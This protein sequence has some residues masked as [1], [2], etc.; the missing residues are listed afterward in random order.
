LSETIEREATILSPADVAAMDSRRQLRCY[1]TFILTLLVAYVLGA[2]EYWHWA[3]WY[4]GHIA[5]LYGYQDRLLH[6]HAPWLA[7]QSRVLAPLLIAAIRWVTGSDY[8]GAYQAF[9]FWTFVGINC[10]A[11]LLYRLLGL[12]IGRSIVGLLLAAAVPMLLLNYWWF[13]WTNLECML[14][15]LLFSIDATAWKTGVRTAA[16]GIVF[17]ALVLTKETAVFVPIWIFLRRMTTLPW[18]F[19]W[20]RV[21]PVAALSFAMAIASLVVDSELRRTLW[22][23]G[24]IPGWPLG[25]P[26]SAAVLGGSMPNLLVWPRITANYYIQ[27]ALALVTGRMPWP[28]VNNPHWADHSAGAIDFF[29]ILGVSVGGAVRSH[30]QRESTLLAL[31]LLSISYLL[32]CVV[33]INMAESDKLLP[34]LAMGAYAYAIANRDG[35]ISR[36]LTGPIPS[37]GPDPAMTDV[38]IA[39]SPN[40]VAL[41]RRPRGRRQQ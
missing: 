16:I 15:L 2:S 5:D 8:A 20:R 40:R 12:S 10:A 29:V 31:S 3:Q 13:P 34:T 25:Y 35:S 28:L 9:M 1:K 17:L 23:S 18:P 6:G 19:P 32:V 36:C 41:H 7:D 39:A 14:W 27:D 37:I 4:V 21:V 11:A 26:P 38:V 30:R 24:T 22:V 33:M